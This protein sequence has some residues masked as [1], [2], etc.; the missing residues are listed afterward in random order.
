VS[1]DEWITIVVLVATFIALVLDRFPPSGVVLTATVVLLVAGVTSASEAFSG[2]SNPAPI[3]VAALLCWPQRPSE[4][5]CCPRQLGGSSEDL[6]VVGWPMQGLLFPSAAASAVFNNTPLVAM[7]IP[8]VIAWSRRYKRDASRYLLPLSYAAILGGTL[9]VLGTS[10]NLIATGLLAD[11]GQDA[12]GIFEVTKIGLPVAIVGMIVLF[13]VS[14]PLMPERVST[15][16]QLNAAVRE[17]LMEM[18]V[19]IDGSI[20]GKTV[21]QAGLRGLAGVYLVQIRHDGRTPAPVGPDSL[22]ESGDVLVF[23][24]EISNVLDLQPM[25]GLE[26]VG[27]HEVASLDVAGRTLYEVVVGRMSPVAGRTLRQAN[28]RERYG[29]AVLAVHRAGHRL[30][31]KLG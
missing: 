22:L 14:I 20:A 13:G 25:R 2:F 10:T 21:E 6:G 3:T 1:T 23:A 28:F 18:R 19:V 11:A 8:D 30:E 4:P 16:A 31:V 29:A 15:P 7:L 12:L 9:T 17:F 24:G 26:S 27:Q 5:G